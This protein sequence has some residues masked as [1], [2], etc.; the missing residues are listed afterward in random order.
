M[1]LKERSLWLGAVA[2]LAACVGLAAAAFRPGQ[3]QVVGE[4]RA[5]GAG[6]AYTVVDT[7]AT[8]LIVTDNR[9]NT[10]YFYT[11]D[12]GAEIGSELKLRG[13]IDLNQVGKPSLRPTRSNGGG[14]GGR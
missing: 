3:T 9:T 6:P 10:L 7:E 13:T 14:G 1:S 4:G 5:A 2:V 12:Q 11:I 8:N